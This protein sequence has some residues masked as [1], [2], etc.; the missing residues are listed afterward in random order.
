MLG[1]GPTD[2]RCGNAIAAVSGAW[3]GR[4]FAYCSYDV[5]VSEEELW[6]CGGENGGSEPHD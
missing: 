4:L 6:S 1:V 3:R 5:A 2:A